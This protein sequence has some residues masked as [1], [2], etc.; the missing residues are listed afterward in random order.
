MGKKESKRSMKLRQFA[1]LVTSAFFLSFLIFSTPHRVHHFFDEHKLPDRF[2]TG[3]NDRQ[4]NHH[5]TNSE[6]T[7]CVFQTVAKTCHV[8]VS[9]AVH[10]F[11]V[12]VF[13]K[14]VLLPSDARVPS[15]FLLNAL[16]I[17]A[18]PEF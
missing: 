11:S 1:Y 10:V 9:S 15:R 17:R 2:T 14:T 13:I 16:K 3:N 6:E 12:P 8:S 4:G 5:R 18:P 7:T